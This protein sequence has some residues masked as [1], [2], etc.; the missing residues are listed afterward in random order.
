VIAFFFF[1]ETQS[2]RRFHTPVTD[3][4]TRELG[5]TR[6]GWHPDVPY[7]IGS[8]EREKAIFVS[9]PSSLSLSSSLLNQGS[10]V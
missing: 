4:L 6:T 9:L 8:F 5:R 10:A 1:T 3:Y 7:L 2:S